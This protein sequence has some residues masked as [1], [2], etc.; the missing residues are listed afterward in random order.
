MSK[1]RKTT[2]RRPPSDRL[3]LERRLD[4]IEE[5]YAS[6]PHVRSVSALLQAQP[7]PGEDAPMPRRTADWYAK[8]VRDRIMARATTARHHNLAVA[9]RRLDA[10]YAGARSAR[11]H[12]DAAFIADRRADLDG[13]RVA[14]D[15]AQ[16]PSLLDQVDALRVRTLD[17]MPTPPPAELPRLTPAQQRFWLR[18]ALHLAQRATDSAAALRAFGAPPEEEGARRLW[19]QRLQAAVAHIAAGSPGLTPAQRREAIARLAS[20]Y[21]MLTRDAELAGELEEFKQ[22]LGPLLLES[23]A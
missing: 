11:R 10:C 20:S 18:R 2:P 8:K 5:I 13:S 15:E 16:E 14:A 6:N 1:P 12:K 23:G 9:I 3:T 22:R 7:L 4:A 19:F 17:W 21:A